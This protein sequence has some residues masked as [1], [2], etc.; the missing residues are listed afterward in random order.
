MKWILKYLGGTLDTCFCFTT[1]DLKLE[2][3]VDA[4]LASDINSRKNTIGLC[5]L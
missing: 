5:S 2:G 1:S 4:N 3:F